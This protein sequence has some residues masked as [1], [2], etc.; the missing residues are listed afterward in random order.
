M[1][2]VTIRSERG[3]GGGWGASGGLDG[4]PRSLTYEEAV[5]HLERLRGSRVQYF[6][7]PREEGSAVPV[8]VV[9]GRAR[10]HGEAEPDAAEEIGQNEN[11]L[12]PFG[13]SS[14]T[15]PVGFPID[16]TGLA[17]PRDW[18][19]GAEADEDGALSIDLA[20]GARLVLDPVDREG[21]TP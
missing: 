10:P 1:T 9:L 20:N 7:G 16:F 3:G 13:V 12:L 6:A 19:A 4:G 11:W 18:F 15:L 8:W 17:V 14:G 5:A 2:N 21:G